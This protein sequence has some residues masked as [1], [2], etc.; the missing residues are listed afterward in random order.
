MSSG[1]VDL[2]STYARS[3]CIF[4]ANLPLKENLSLVRGDKIKGIS[5]INSAQHISR[6]S[7]FASKLKAI[8]T[9]FPEREIASTIWANVLKAL[10]S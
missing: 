8:L 4:L 6:R 2:L 3:K 10:F 5:D 7:H 9:R 1:A